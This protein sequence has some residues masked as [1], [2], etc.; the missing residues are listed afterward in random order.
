MEACN[1][2][3]ATSGRQFGSRAYALNLYLAVSLK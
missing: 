1:L 2:P 3:K